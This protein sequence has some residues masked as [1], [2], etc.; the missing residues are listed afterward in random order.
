MKY[1]IYTLSNDYKIDQLPSNELNSEIADRLTVIEKEIVMEYLKKQKGKLGI[2][3]LGNEIRYNS[4][5][6]NEFNTQKNNKI[7]I[8]MTENR[9]AF[10]KVFLDN[11]VSHNTSDI[12]YFILEN[13][14]G[15]ESNLVDAS[16]IR[17]NEIN[18]EL[19]KFFSYFRKTTTGPRVF[20][21]EMKGLS[22]Y[23][24]IE[25]EGFSYLQLNN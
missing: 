15:G 19:T 23:H 1:N 2:K 3:K 9:R 17:K 18:E 8:K 5:L 21:I 24:I 7:I 4:I 14:F 25:N 12:Y 22:K 20:F 16:F 10:I 11:W 13:T 6:K